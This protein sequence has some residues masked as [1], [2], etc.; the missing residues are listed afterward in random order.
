MELYDGSSFPFDD[1][2][3]DVVIFM[4]VLHHTDHALDLLQEANRVCKQFIIV[5]DHL[6]DSTFASHTLA[7]MDWIGNRS[8]G[9]ALPYN[10]WSSGQWRQ[11][12]QELGTSPD[13]TVSDIGLYPWFAKPLFE[14]GLH[15]IARLPVTSNQ[16]RPRSS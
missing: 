12:W 6:C 16:R 10:Y 1:D 15:F 2:S 9:V 8:H 4:D 13:I 11:V 3:F 5:K 7:F 14:N